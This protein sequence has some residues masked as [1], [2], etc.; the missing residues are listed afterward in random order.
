M[1]HIVVHRQFGGQVFKPKKRHI[2][3]Y[4]KKKKL[5]IV[6]HLSL[7]YILTDLFHH[8]DLH[9]DVYQINKSP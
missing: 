6:A 9:A 2:G 8:S 3:I 4:V 7:A 1:E 5:H